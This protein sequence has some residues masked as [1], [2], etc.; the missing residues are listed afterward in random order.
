MTK[1]DNLDK[2]IKSIA[3]ETNTI[4]VH[5]NNTFNSFINLS[6]SKY[7]IENVNNL[8]EKLIIKLTNRRISPSRIDVNKLS[9]DGM[10]DVSLT[11]ITDNKIRMQNRLAKYT[12]SIKF[13]MDIY[14]VQIIWMKMKFH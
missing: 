5:L 1:V 14:N 6:N 7:F 2:Y 12:A 10:V 8:L 11:T 13:Y 9:T 3:S 4:A